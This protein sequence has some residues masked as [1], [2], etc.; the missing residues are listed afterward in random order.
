MPLRDDLHRRR[1]ALLAIAARHGVSNLRL[2]GS[3]I[4]GEERADSD[5]D[6]LVDMAE[7]RG[8]GDYLALVEELEGALARRV[9]VVIERSLSPHFR[10]YIEAEAQPL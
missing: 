3:V 8:F 7:D 10:P 6:L 5:I 9:D 4:R 2:F 1:D